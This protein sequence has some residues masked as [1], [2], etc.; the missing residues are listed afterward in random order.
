MAEKNKKSIAELVEKWAR[1]KNKDPNDPAYKQVYAEALRS[2]EFI[3]YVESGELPEGATRKTKSWFDGLV[4]ESE[5][6]PFVELN[7]LY[8]QYGATDD[9]GQ[10]SDIYNKIKS[11]PDFVASSMYEDDPDEGVMAGKKALQKQW[12]AIQRGDTSKENTNKING[13]ILKFLEPYQRN[14][15]PESFDRLNKALAANFGTENFFDL[16]D[17]PSKG[18]YSDIKNRVG[19][20][21]SLA[22]SNPNSNN[23]D[24][25]IRK[26]KPN[27]ASTT[28]VAPIFGQ[29]KDELNQLTQ[30][31]EIP[32]EI[33]GP[34]QGN[35]AHGYISTPSLIQDTIAAGNYRKK[36]I[37]DNPTIQ[38]AKGVQKWINDAKQK[39]KE[40]GTA[41]DNL[42]EQAKTYV[43]NT[44]D[45]QIADQKA[46]VKKGVSEGAKNALMNSFIMNPTFEDEATNQLFKSLGQKKIDLID[47][48]DNELR[49]E[50]ES[51]S[52][53]D[54]LN[55]ERALNGNPEWEFTKSKL[56]GYVSEENKNSQDYIDALTPIVNQLGDEDL[57]KGL[58]AVQTI[59]DSLTGIIGE[60]RQGGL[61]PEEAKEAAELYKQ[62]DE[63]IN[64]EI[65]N[66]P[67][68]RAASQN[69]R[70]QI[71]KTLFYVF[72]NVKTMF[73]M[74][75]SAEAGA[76]QWI[77][78]AMEKRNAE[79]AKSET[80]FAVKQQD[81]YTENM[82]R[83]LTE[84]NIADYLNKTE[85]QPLLEKLRGQYG[86]EKEEVP[87]MVVKGLKKAYEQFKEETGKD[88]EAGFAAWY[89]QHSTTSG[90][91]VSLLLRA[92]LQNAGN[93][94]DLLN[95]GKSGKPG[96]VSYGMDK[97]GK[98]MASIFQNAGNNA[99]Q[100]S[101]NNIANDASSTSFVSSIV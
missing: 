97:D 86:I 91:A 33:T 96:N 38:S 70:D 72:D 93:I 29:K 89:L 81:A 1:F 4:E 35:N 59:S 65:K 60:E 20:M 21:G 37:N 9:V 11:H 13:P 36:T 99:R 50:L 67:T 14:I 45:Q 68:I 87:G 57:A 73:F 71:N 63:I 83:D 64:S 31:P 12:E 74:A 26:T 30:S 98:K 58:E 55:I 85:I 88:D 17:A 80:N 32:Y 8:K 40:L 61:T 90:D 22:A 47:Y 25:P 62:A 44:E 10:R 5:R 53:M 94:Q 49:P 48:Y 76:P 56:L 39:S 69:L 101:A 15:S 66:D 79:I 92:L 34:E 100:A 77:P 18:V 51:L 27:T 78:S 19:K 84:D 41:K 23:Q 2:P 16:L 7:D 28:Q 43:E 54:E 24:L 42:A 52:D 6:N 46:A 82:F 3:K 95:G 75:L